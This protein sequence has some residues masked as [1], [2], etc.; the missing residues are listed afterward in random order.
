MTIFLLTIWLYTSGVVYMGGGPPTETII[1]S[2]PQE[3]ATILWT[4]N[5]HVDIWSKWNATLY[6][7]N[8]KEGTVKETPIPK[9]KFE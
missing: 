6:E 9:V 2:S 8:T 7:V 3:A 5:Q 1:V 4:R